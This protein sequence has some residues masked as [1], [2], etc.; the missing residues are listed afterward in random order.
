MESRIRSGER[1]LVIAALL[2]LTI[3]AAYAQSQPAAGQCITSSVPP[4]VRSEGLTERLGDLILQCS[5]ATPGAVITSNYAISL[6]VNV[7]NRI[8]NNNLTTDAVLY[9]DYGLGYT[10]ASV[11]GLVSGNTIS[12]NG[13]NITVPATGK[14]NLKFSNIRADAHQ[15]TGSAPT[16]ITASISS[17][18][19]ITQ[20]Q[21]IV[22][23]AQPGLFATVYNTGIT[24]TGS[25]LPATLDLTDLFA[26][27]T[28]FFSTR[29]TTGFASAFAPRG[30]GETNGTR[31]LVMYSGFP[32]NTTLYVPNLVAGSDATVP[33]AGGDLGGIQSGGQYLPGSGTLLLA[34][35]LG[36]DATG[37]G[38]TP[39][40]IPTGTTPV[41]LNSASQV[42]LTNGS[43]YAVYEVADAGTT[44]IESAQFPT[45]IGLPNVTA[46]AVAQESI[47]LAPVSA[48]TTASSSAPVPRFAA[49]TPASDC[50]ILGDCGAAYFPKLNVIN[51][52][53][54][55]TATAGTATGST[56]GY[57]YV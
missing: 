16:P 28:A 26:A 11:P 20:G 57:I 36:A 32:S 54:Q 17:A 21:A 15:L 35:V 55:I 46:P 39:V 43:G 51:L 47:S 41:A 48:A 27:R 9:V 3:S 31:F 52:P 29:V 10:P 2:T 30:N 13:A 4:T 45:F 53:V 37:A 23:F 19:Q 8:D 42:P 25:Q 18:L 12:F 6:P 22:A 49:V 38:G 5:G 34:L 7:T 56:P 44:R 33:T 14:F 50:S 40:P 1:L 24:C